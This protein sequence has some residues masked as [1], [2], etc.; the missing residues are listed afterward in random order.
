M[1]ELEGLTATKVL[2]RIWMVCDWVVLLARISLSIG[3]WPARMTAFAGAPLMIWFAIRLEPAKLKRTLLLVSF[4][5]WVWISVRTSTRDAAAW[6]RGVSVVVQEIVMIETMA[7]RM[8]EFK[9][10]LNI[11]LT[12]LLESEVA[13]SWVRLINLP[14]NSAE[15]SMSN[16]ESYHAS[17]EYSFTEFSSL[18]FYRR[19]NSRLVD[20]SG[21]FN[22]HKIIDLGCGTGGI[23]KLILERLTG[24]KETVIYAVDHSASALRAAVE[25]LG[26]RKEAAI[27]FVHAEVQNLTGSVNEQVDAVIYCNSIHYVNDKQELLKQIRERLKPGGILAFNTSF[28]EG[29]HPPESLDFYRRWMMRALRTLRRD[30]GLFPDKNASKTDA[31]RQLTPE[32]Y[33]ELLKE[34]G[35]EVVKKESVVVPVPVDG[36]HHISGFRDW[37]EGVMPGVPLGKGRDALQKS[38]RQVFKEMELEAVPRIW[39]GI[40]ARRAD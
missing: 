12:C 11:E 29:A 19:V 20:M 9:R 17:D 23:T 22:Q 35:F 34:A 8:T 5:Y 4:S 37:I 2:V 7:R 16:P 1:V 30:H 39:L 15:V 3:V 25:E 40:T 14:T 32:E 6:M 27:R 31:R 18:P 28:F 26:G 36:F 38:L 10:V 33:E 13:P 21:V 24:T